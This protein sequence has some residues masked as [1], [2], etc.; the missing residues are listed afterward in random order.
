MENYGDWK[1]VDIWVLVKVVWEGATI[2]HPLKKITQILR[3][4]NMFQFWVE[5]CEGLP[6]SG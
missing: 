5:I 1:A 4:W 6:E 3:S 2:Y